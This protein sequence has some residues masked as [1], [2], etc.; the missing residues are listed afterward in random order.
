MCSRRDASWHGSGDICKLRQV[1]PGMA[2]GHVVSCDPAQASHSCVL[3]V[4][5][6]SC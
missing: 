6:V 5:V 4:G 2:G 1:P 3:E